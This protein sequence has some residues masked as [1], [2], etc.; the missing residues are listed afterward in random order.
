M[1]TQEQ[2]DFLANTPLFKITADK[3][4]TKDYFVNEIKYR[5][6]ITITEEVFI[7]N[8]FKIEQNVSIDKAGI[9][10][11]V[12]FVGYVLNEGKAVH[13]IILAQ[14]LTYQEKQFLVYENDFITVTRIDK[15]FYDKPLESHYSTVSKDPANLG[16]VPFYAKLNPQP[17]R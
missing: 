6:L 16:K 2:K 9:P 13:E 10:R 3:H 7:D 8:R 17:V 1:L 14:F 12:E 15:I 11:L 5:D 4:L